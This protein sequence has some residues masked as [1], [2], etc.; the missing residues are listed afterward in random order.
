MSGFWTRK[1]KT[2]GLLRSVSLSVI[3][4]SLIFL[5]HFQQ[6][7]YMVSLLGS[8]KVPDLYR[9][10][11]QSVSILLSQ[12]ISL[13]L[14]S[15]HQVNAKDWPGSKRRSNIFTFWRDMSQRVCRCVLEPPQQAI[16]FIH[17]PM[18]PQC[19]FM[20]LSFPFPP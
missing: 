20:P 13:L 19:T 18:L 6:P 4:W 1:F 10:P 15:I 7:L 9:L 17:T 8:L 14:L 16:F 11:D 12:V 3:Y 2:A 5:I